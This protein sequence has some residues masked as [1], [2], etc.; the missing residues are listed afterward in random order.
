M[1]GGWGRPER[2]RAVWESGENGE[3]NCSRNVLITRM[4]GNRKL[5]LLRRANGTNCRLTDTFVK[6]RGM[7]GDINKLVKNTAR[8]PSVI[9][10]C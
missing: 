8:M 2:K 6:M 4:E 7:N 10:F 5:V 3:W 9:C 1:P